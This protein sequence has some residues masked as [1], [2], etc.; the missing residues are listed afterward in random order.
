[1][2]YFSKTGAFRFNE[3]DDIHIGESF[4]AGGVNR[5]LTVWIQTDTEAVSFLA[6]DHIFDSGSGWINFE[7]PTGI[8]SVLGGVS[9][10][11]LVI[12]AVS[13]PANS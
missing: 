2:A 13:A 8:R 9:E 11:D 12:I 7:T 1:M 6:K 10:G 3:A 5:E 4:A